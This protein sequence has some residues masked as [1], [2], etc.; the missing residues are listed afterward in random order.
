MGDTDDR[1]CFHTKMWSTGLIAFVSS[2]SVLLL[3]YLSIGT[4]V[5]LRR[6]RRQINC[7]SPWLLLISHIGNTC[8]AVLLLVQ[9]TGVVHA[10]DILTVEAAT[11]FCHFLCYFPYLL[12][13][14]RL[15]F[16]FNS[17]IGRTVQEEAYFLRHIIRSKQTWLLRALVLL[18]VPIFCICVLLCTVRP[19]EK[20][21]P[22]STHDNH[23]FQITYIAVSF[24]EQILFMFAI[25][26][27]RNVEKDFSMTRELLVVCIVWYLNAALSYHFPDSP[28]LYGLMTRTVIITCI[29]MVTPLVQSFR[30]PQMKE[31]LTLQAMYSLHIVLQYELPLEY[32]E[33]FLSSC[34]SPIAPSIPQEEE[35]DAA[36]YAVLQLYLQSQ[37]HKADPLEGGFLESLKEFTSKYSIF[38]ES[39]RKRIETE[40]ESTG[41]EAEKSLFN[42]L[43]NYYFP[44]FQRSLLFG[45][46]CSF[47][48]Q[49]E[50]RSERIHCTSFIGDD[51]K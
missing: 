16:V 50:L 1:V 23:T 39:L 18:M 24:S 32:F 15:Y 10:P 7:R 51:S 47:V 22:S 9:I 3:I 42:L 36:G 13:A 38:S 46:L 2:A 44:K 30:M 26:A 11:F 6:N 19:V 8:E 41:E 4:L 33:Q 45:K 34:S 31:Q 35:L 20:D 12:R 29:S 5:L 49:S 40:D 14:Y 25:Y 28:W 27:L 37:I 43:R 48:E 17:E 21:H